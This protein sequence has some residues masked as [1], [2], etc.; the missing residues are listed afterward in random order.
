MKRG[1][2]VAELGAEVL[3]QPSLVERASHVGHRGRRYDVAD[4]LEARAG[5]GEA[6]LDALGGQADDVDQLDRVAVPGAEGGVVAELSRLTARDDVLY[7]HV[8]DEEDRSGAELVDQAIHGRRD[9]GD[10]VGVMVWLAEP[11]SKQ[12]LGQ[13]L[14][15]SLFTRG[16]PGD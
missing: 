11:R 8:L 5:A 1:L 9:V 4:V 2:D 10:D 6:P 13:G 12:V 16:R 3:H 15:L 7:R 14:S